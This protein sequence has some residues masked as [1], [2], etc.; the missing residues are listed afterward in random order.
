MY[1]CAELLNGVCQS[2]VEHKPL[3]ALSIEDGLMIGGSFLLA[4]ATAFGL[5]L[6]ARFLLNR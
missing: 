1:Y 3:F 5:N 4:S 6:I 2:W